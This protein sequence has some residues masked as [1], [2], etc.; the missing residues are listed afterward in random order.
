MN[1]NNKILIFGSCVSRD[2]FNLPNN[3]QLTNYYARSSFASIMQPVFID[4][5][6]AQRI[7]SSFQSKV[8]NADMKKIFL[9][10]LKEQNFDILFLDFIDERFNLLKI[11]QTICTLSIEAVNTGFLDEYRKK[12]IIQDNNSWFFKLHLDNTFITKNPNKIIKSGN[13]EFLKM[14][15]HGWKEF[16]ELMKEQNCLK[17]VILNKVYWAEET[18]SSQNFEPT[19]PIQHILKMN[20]MLDHLYSIAERSLPPENVMSFSKELMV[21]ADEHQWGISPFHYVSE[22]YESALS[23][24]DNWEQYPTK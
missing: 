5:A 3:Y 1:I 16:I 10:E 19:Y 17:K 22:Y 8:V 12:G 9:Q 7:K 13:K 4:H 15:E 14:W 11:N 20:K 24:L 21:G 18:L 23:A 2:I 6:I